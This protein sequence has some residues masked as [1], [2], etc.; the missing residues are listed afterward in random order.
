MVMESKC[1]LM[2]LDMK[3]A[4]Q[5][6]KLM[7]LV[8]CIMQMVT[9]MRENGKMIRLMVEG[10]IHML[11]ELD[12]QETGRMINNMVMVLKHGLMEQCMKVSIMKERRTE[13]VN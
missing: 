3:E 4:G 10:L 7:D 1:G 13:K 8:S 5:M 6:T 9:F 2:N 11:M 12:I